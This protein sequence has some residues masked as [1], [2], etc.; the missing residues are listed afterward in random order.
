MK[1]VL[2]F[3]LQMGN[4]EDE[5]NSWSP[6]VRWGCAST[7][8]PVLVDREEK[9]NWEECERTLAFPFWGQRA[10]LRI[11]EA[12]LLMRRR[13][14]VDTATAP[15]SYIYCWHASEQHISQAQSF[16]LL[17]QNQISESYLIW[18]AKSESQMFSSIQTQMPPQSHTEICLVCSF[19]FLVPLQKKIEER[20]FASLWIENLLEGIWFHKLLMSKEWYQLLILDTL[21][22]VHTGTSKSWLWDIDEY[23]Q[24]HTVKHRRKFHLEKQTY[25]SYF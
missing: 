14:R 11:L 12:T 23:S 15:N 2:W 16:N 20:Y 1:F 10:G 25:L 9:L 7:K 22:S 13:K 6:E 4:G 8:V 19:T 17:T 21:I 24:V 3:W 5:K 18:M